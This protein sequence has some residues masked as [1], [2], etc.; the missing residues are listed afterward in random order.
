MKMKKPVAYRFDEALLE[1]LVRFIGQ[2][3][4]PPTQTAVVEAALKE[5]LDREEPEG[6]DKRAARR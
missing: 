4:W 6:G 3:K 1:R 5:Y 2:H